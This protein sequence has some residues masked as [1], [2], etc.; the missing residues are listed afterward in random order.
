MLDLIE[1]IKDEK[2]VE[3]PKRWKNWFEARQEMDVARSTEILRE[4][5]KYVTNPVYPS[6]ELAEEHHLKMM[7]NSMYAVACGAAKYIGAFPEGE[8]P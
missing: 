3:P 8:R 4:G 1:D 6:K 7:T 5:D 2:I